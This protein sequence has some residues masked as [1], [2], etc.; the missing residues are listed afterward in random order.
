L[1]LPNLNSLRGLSI[2]VQGVT[3]GTTTLALTNGGQARLGD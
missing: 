1:P 3:L 2:F